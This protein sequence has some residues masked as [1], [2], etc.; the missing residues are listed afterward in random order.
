V[1]SPVQKLGGAGSLARVKSFLRDSGGDVAQ[2]SAE[3]A[4]LVRRL[5]RVKAKTGRRIALSPFVAELLEK[6]RRVEVV[7]G[8]LHPARA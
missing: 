4:D 8:H 5:E 7:E 2:V 1:R 6:S 3:V